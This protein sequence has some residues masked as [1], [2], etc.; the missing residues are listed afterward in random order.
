MKMPCIK[1]PI[2]V[3]A[4]LVILGCTSPVYSQSGMLRCGPEIV[5]IGDSMYLVKERC[6][7]PADVKVFT[8]DPY[9]DGRR[10]GSYQETTVM[11][12][13][14][15]GTDFIYKLTF[16]GDTLTYIQPIGRGSGSGT[17]R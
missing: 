8:S 15:G 9:G 3:L 12:Y 1:W 6:G 16:S 7:Q 4:G 2:L 11:I 5:Q 10:D 17:C 13:N 14:C